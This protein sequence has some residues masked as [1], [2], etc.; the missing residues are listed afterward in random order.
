MQYFRNVRHNYVASDAFAEI[1]KV[2]SSPDTLRLLLSVFSFMDGFTS[3]EST[4]LCFAWHCDLSDIP[5]PLAD[6]T[7]MN[8]TVTLLTISVFVLCAV[9]KLYTEWNNAQHVIAPTTTTIL[10]TTA[11]TWFI[12]H[13]LAGTSKILQIYIYIHIYIY[14]YIYIS[15]DSSLFLLLVPPPRT[16]S[17]SVPNTWSVDPK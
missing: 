14:I 13:K 3:M 4:V 12:H 17:T 16:L 6:C 10:P 2:T 7:A 1:V 15:G 11:V 8:G 5:K 9:F